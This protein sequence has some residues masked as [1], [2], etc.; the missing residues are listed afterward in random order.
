MWNSLSLVLTE[1]RSSILGIGKPFR[2]SEF[3]KHLMTSF[4]HETLLD[5]RQ[6][7][8]GIHTRKQPHLGIE[9]P[10]RQCEGVLPETSDDIFYHE[11]LSG[12]F[13]NKTFGKS[14]CTRLAMARRV[15][16]RRRHLRR[17][18]S[19][20]PGSVVVRL[21]FYPTWTN[22]CEKES[23]IPEDLIWK[24]K[25]DLERKQLIEV[26]IPPCCLGRG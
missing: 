15:S 11:T 4:Y 26:I 24:R 5:P 22:V 23:R 8:F 13:T 7:Y 9:K 14:L 1:Q 2:Q 19:L 3:S 10:F 6:T 21:R 18:S 20:N 25:A 12:S 17:C 16:E